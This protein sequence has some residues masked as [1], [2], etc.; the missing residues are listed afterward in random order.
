MGRKTRRRSSGGGP[1]EH[2]LAVE[3]PEINRDA[4]AA[5]PKS[6]HASA[7]RLTQKNTALKQEYEHR[8]ELLQTERAELQNELA[9][10]RQRLDAVERD[11]ELA[12]RLVQQQAGQILRMQRELAEHGTQAALIQKILH[13]ASWRVTAPLR[14]AK[15]MLKR[16][17]PSATVTK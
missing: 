8:L 16:I 2:T 9:N 11:R 13:S 7:D 4:L 3:K 17:I 6:A 12:A 10:V 5:D 1:P 15:L 14:G